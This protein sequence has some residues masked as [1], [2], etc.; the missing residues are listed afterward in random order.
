MK[1]REQA[2]TALHLAALELLEAGMYPAR[3]RAL[4]HSAVMSDGD[5]R[6]ERVAFLFLGTLKK[7]R[8]GRQVQA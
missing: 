3:F 5:T 2:L 8:S 1:G 4:A 7:V 6:A